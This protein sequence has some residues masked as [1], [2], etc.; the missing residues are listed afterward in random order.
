MEQKIHIHLVVQFYKLINH[1][2]GIN[3]TNR[4]SFFLNLMVLTMMQITLTKSHSEI[5]QNNLTILSN[6][7]PSSVWEEFAAIS[8]P[9]GSGNEAKVA[10]YIISQALISGCNAF[11][12]NIGNVIVRKSASSTNYENVPY[13]TIQSHMDMVCEKNK[14]VQHDFTKDEIR[15]V[16][17]DNFLYA[18]GTTLGADNGIGVAT[19]LSII[20]SKNLI[21][22]PL[23]FLFTVHEEDGFDGAFNIKPESLKGRILLNIDTEEQ[24]SIYIGCAGSSYVLAELPIKREKLVDNFKNLTISVDGLRGGHS[25]VDID[26]KDRPNSFQL[27]NSILKNLQGIDFR[28]ISIDGGNKRNAIA[29]DVEIQMLILAEQE[30]LFNSRFSEITKALI[31]EFDQEKNL[32]FITNSLDSKDNDV[33]SEKDQKNLLSLLDKMPHGVIK[34]SE[35][36]DNLVE[37]STNF[38]RI[39]TNN[40]SISFETMQRSLIRSELDKIAKEVQ[41][42]SI[43]YGANA[44][45]EF[46]SPEWEPNPNSPILNLAK[47]TYKKLFSTDAFVKAIHA[48]LECGA[49]AQQIP[50][51]DTISFGPTIIDAHSPNEHVDINTVQPFWNFLTKLIEDFAEQKK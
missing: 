4:T 1:A 38:A 29:R 24:D 9:R 23:E 28:I 33:L 3:M 35:K 30:N 15:F 37:T 45:I 40:D 36:I 34:M 43:S 13:L 41:N 21:H 6:L 49:F 18:D 16:H 19:A 51:L 48:G 26:K 8:I 32:K 31:K 7:K 11:K 50:G 10:E 47:S 44:K 2:K 5:R 22:G 25:G 12:D 27:A 42:V 14:D 39:S 46:S 17:K 20:K